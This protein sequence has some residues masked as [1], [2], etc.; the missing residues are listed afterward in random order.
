MTILV[1]GASGLLGSHVVDALLDRGEAPRALVGPDDAAGRLDALGIETLRGDVRDRQ[2]LD[3]AVEGV[4]AVLHCAARTGPWGPEEEYRSTNV[5]GLGTL[6]DACRTAGVRRIVHVSSITVHGNDVHGWADETSPIRAGTN[7]YSRSKIAGEELLQRLASAG[8]PVTIVRPGYLY[9]PGDV[10]SFARFATMIREGRMVVIGPGTNHIPLVYV[11]DVA[12]GI[13]QAA[14]SERAIGRT[15]LLVNDEPVTQAAYLSAIADELGVAAPSRHVPY[16]LAVGL[17]AGCEFAAR[18]AH[19]RQPPPVMRY[20]VQVLGGENRFSIKRARNE[21][22]FSP[23]VPLRQG[24]HRS[25]EWYRSDRPL[26]A[27]TRSA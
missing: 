7:P 1:T 8:A 25:I 16:P 27:T 21:L 2:V 15:Y 22:G 26:A 4:D 11:R 20:G 5:T 10:A 23:G 14:S 9:G 3:A 12:D 18:V 13:L 17:G 24:V 6:V 19:R